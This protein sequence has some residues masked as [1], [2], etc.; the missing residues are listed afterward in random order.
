MNATSTYLCDALAGMISAYAMS[1]DN[2]F[3]EISNRN[4]SDG[5]AI[6][7]SLG[8]HGFDINVRDIDEECIIVALAFFRDMSQ[9]VSDDVFKRMAI[10]R[11]PKSTDECR[12]QIQNS[13][14]FKFGFVEALRRQ[15]QKEYEN[16]RKISGYQENEN[17]RN[18]ERWLREVMAV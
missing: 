18:T 16:K 13:A 17:V 2:K 7:K 9:T 3:E 5:Y 15:L 12:Q 11:L 6:I 10:K 8:I 1:S 14:A 4:V